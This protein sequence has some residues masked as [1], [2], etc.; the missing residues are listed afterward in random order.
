M[1]NY[2]EINLTLYLTSLKD[3]DMK[4][5]IETMAKIKNELSKLIECFTEKIL[6]FYVYFY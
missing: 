5:N 6:Y 2:N 1:E 3:F 4:Y